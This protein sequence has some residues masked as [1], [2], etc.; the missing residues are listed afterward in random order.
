M[1]KTTYANDKV[2]KRSVEFSTRR[3]YEHCTRSF[4]TWLP[5]EDTYLLEN[6]T[7]TNIEYLSHVHKRSHNAIIV[8]YEQL[9]KN[10]LK[11]IKK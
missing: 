9:R 2:K 5:N 1:F 6:F 8:R 11:W 10:N 3:G 7:G 4:C